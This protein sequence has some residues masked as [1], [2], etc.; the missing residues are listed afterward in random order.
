MSPGLKAL[1]E[2][3]ERER[4][5]AILAAHGRN[6]SSQREKEV[7]LIRAGIA[8]TARR[9][10]R[11]RMQR[12]AVRELFAKGMGAKE[13]GARLGLSERSVYAARSAFEARP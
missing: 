13:I 10:E 2:K 11:L 12:D 6:L 3:M 8:S 7:G 1:I 4:E 5:A 9:S